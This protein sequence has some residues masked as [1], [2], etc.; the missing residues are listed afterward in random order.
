MC[1]FRAKCIHRDRALT[2]SS[3]RLGAPPQA[4][5]H[6]CLWVGQLKFQRVATAFWA[7]QKNGRGLPS[8]IFSDCRYRLPP[9]TR[10]RLC[11][12]RKAGLG[13]N[14]VRTF[15]DL[16]AHPTVALGDATSLEVVRKDRKRRLGHLIGRSGIACLLHSETFDDGECL[17]AATIKMRAA[18]PRQNCCRIMTVASPELLP[19]RE[20][21]GGRDEAG[22]HG[23]EG[24]IACRGE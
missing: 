14:F 2:P 22:Q 16:L 7:H 21:G 1:S 17:W 4:G 20:P 3:A 6:F 23:D 8:L 18:L 9:E 10:S 5:R 12:V 13:A 24:R 19:R 15:A 11:I